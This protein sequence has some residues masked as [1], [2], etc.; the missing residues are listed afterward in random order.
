MIMLKEGHKRTTIVVED[1]LW[2]AFRVEAAGQNKS[3]SD[4]LREVLRERQMA[5]ENEKAA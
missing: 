1:K 3:A 2:T 4:L 5:L